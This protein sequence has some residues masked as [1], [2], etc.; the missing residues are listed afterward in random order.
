MDNIL[1][2]ALREFTTG[3]LNQLIVNLGG[4][5]G[6]QWEQQLKRFLRKEPCWIFTNAELEAHTK[7]IVGEP[8]IIKIDR[9][10]SFNPTEFIS[11][12]WSIWRGPKDGK[13]LS[14]EEEQD[15]RALDLTEVDISKIRLETM[16]KSGE[17][18]V[19]GEERL[20]RLKKAGH[21]R[22]DV[23]IFQIL[24]EN[25]SL[26]PEEWKEK[27]NGNTTFIFFDG[28]ILRGPVGDRGVLCLCWSGGE[29]DWDGD[30]LGD[31]F[32]ADDPSAVLAS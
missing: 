26:I 4:H 1:S 29:W 6:D 17:V 11:S 21:I 27:T 10:K 7:V 30:W 28:T 15:E 18:S 31:G 25:Q 32:G 22:L 20:E 8:K 5:D 14:G 12:G 9:T 23:K 3:P 2:K 24:W 19:G 13:G 16:L